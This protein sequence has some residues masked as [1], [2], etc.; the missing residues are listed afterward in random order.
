MAYKTREELLKEIE[1][2]NNEIKELKKEAE[3]LERYKEYEK[4]ADELA[5]IRDSYINA[6]FSKTEAFEMTKLML[7]LAAK[8]AKLF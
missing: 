7:N 3:R 2:K 1:N 6:G 5:A 8:T 4:G